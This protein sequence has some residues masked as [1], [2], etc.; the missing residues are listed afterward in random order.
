MTAEQR[1]PTTPL[2]PLPPRLNCSSIISNSINIF[3]S[4]NGRSRERLLQARRE[5]E[6][7]TPRQIVH[8]GFELVKRDSTFWSISFL[9]DSIPSGTFT[10]AIKVDRIFKRK[11]DG[12]G[13][14][15]R[16]PHIRIKLL[17][18]VLIISSRPKPRGACLPFHDSLSTGEAAAV[19]F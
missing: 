11:V 7:S 17:G 13:S 12:N 9:R 18:L 3:L 6:D 14:I 16:P 2:R 8:T 1:F 10:W 5:V 15:G 19:S 4:R